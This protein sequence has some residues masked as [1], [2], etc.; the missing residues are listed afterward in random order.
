VTASRYLRAPAAAPGGSGSKPASVIQWMSSPTTIERG[1]SLPQIARSQQAV[2]HR[3]SRGDA[4]LVAG[5]Q[6]QRTPV[7]GWIG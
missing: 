4:Q 7:D 2:D 1:P 5:A 6:A 3:I